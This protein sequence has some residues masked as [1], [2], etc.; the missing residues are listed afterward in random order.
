MLSRSIVLRNAA[1]MEWPEIYQRLQDDLND[2]D[3]WTA[4]ESRVRPWARRALWERGWHAIEDAVAD[5]CSTVALAFA[6]AR[7]AETFSGFVYGHFLNVR[8][9]MLQAPLTSPVLDDPADPAGTTSTPDE[10]ALL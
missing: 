1:R 9:R 4:L 5:T 10:L 3:P 8:R 6:K 2:P 7:G